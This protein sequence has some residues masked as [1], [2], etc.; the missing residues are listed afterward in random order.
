L[1]ISLTNVTA[2]YPHSSGP[3][4][5][6]VS[7]ELDK[8]DF[9][10]VQG[11]TGSGKSTLMKVLSG[12]LE[13]NSGSITIAG[14]HLHPTGKGKAI[15]S[16]IL[17]RYRQTV[18]FVFQDFKLLQDKTIFENIVF[19][20]EMMPRMSR[21]DFVN[22]AER[23]LE[24]LEL[25]AIRNAFPREVSHGEQ[26]QAAIARAVVRE[27]FVLVADEP[28]AQLDAV[29]SI[30]I[31]NVLRAEHRRGMTVILLTSCNTFAIPEADWYDLV[32]GELRSRASAAVNSSAS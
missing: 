4:L 27:P 23:T 12:E 1:I 10:V 29:S 31:L 19:A 18:G 2:Q 5:S 9:G 21:H 14:F 32:S 26:A 13:T 15:Q 7:L 17:A 28:T 8:G 24:R 22:R 25:T 30:D 20:L 3:V 11:A 6:N 16:R